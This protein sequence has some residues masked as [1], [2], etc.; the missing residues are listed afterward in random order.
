MEENFEI[1]LYIIFAVIA[2]LSRL[3]SKKNKAPKPKG[4]P[5]SSKQPGQAPPTFEDLLR[6]FTGA[7]PATETEMEP[8][9]VPEESVFVPQKSYSPLVSDSEARETYERSIREA[10]ARGRE[11]KPKAESP[12]KGLDHF[13]NYK[14]EEEDSGL[15]VF[16]KRLRNLQGAK[17]AFIL[18]EIFNRKY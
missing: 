7:G 9:P 18:S 17:E 6:E 4:T 12:R 3:F 1:F 15:A 16:S 8:E 11:Q 5:T 13:K 2:L 10:N 14:L